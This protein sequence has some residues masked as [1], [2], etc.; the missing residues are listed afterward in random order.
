MPDMEP[1]GCL[2]PPTGETQGT[3]P[4]NAESS[5]EGGPGSPPAPADWR[6]DVRTGTVESVLSG[7]LGASPRVIPSHLL[8]GGRSSHIPQ[9]GTLKLS[10]WGLG[11]YNTFE[12]SL[13]ALVALRG[14]Q[15]RRA[16]R[17]GSRSTPSWVSRSLLHLWLLGRVGVWGR[18]GWPE[19]T[20]LVFVQAAAWRPTA[21]SQGPGPGQHPLPTDTR[22]HTPMPSSDSPRAAPFRRTQSS[23]L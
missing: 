4:R 23:G 15:E 5:V 12:F 9:T 7:G 6:S 16:M 13:G 10:P 21:V 22:L 1:P 8:G 17:G 3:H 11:Y 20:A 19:P 14:A 18:E 2:R